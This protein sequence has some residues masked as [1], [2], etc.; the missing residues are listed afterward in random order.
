MKR[1]G[2]KRWIYVNTVCCLKSVVE[3]I[4]F[5]T[6]RFIIGVY[7][8]GISDYC[9]LFGLC[10]SQALRCLGDLNLPILSLKWV[11]WSST[12]TNL[13]KRYYYHLRTFRYVLKVYIYIYIY[14]YIIC[15]PLIKCIILS[16]PTPKLITHTIGRNELLQRNWN[17]ASQ[18]FLVR[19]PK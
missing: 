16:A 6:C 15:I 7:Q 14:V 4:V 11:G 18:D 12:W 8:P 17:D 13:M 1:G 9:F 2:S 19:Q 5:I 10:L 3:I